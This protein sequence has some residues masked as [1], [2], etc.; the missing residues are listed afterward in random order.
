[1]D[2]VAPRGSVALSALQ[3]RIVDLS[4]KVTSTD[5]LDEFYQIASELKLAL[6]EHAEALK[7]MV[8]TTRK[9]FAVRSVAVTSK[10]ATN[11]STSKED[12]HAEPLAT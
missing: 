7:R 4:F 11:I 1:L 12:G 5:D 6:H 9:R 3:K 10:T 8:H 2:I